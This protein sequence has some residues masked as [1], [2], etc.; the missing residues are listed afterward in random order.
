MIDVFVV[1]GCAVMCPLAKFHDLLKDNMLSAADRGE[2]CA[3]GSASEFFKQSENQFHTIVKESQ[4]KCQHCE[5]KPYQQCC[6]A[7]TCM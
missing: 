1:T 4:P 2:A 6:K 3:D 7:V 5:N